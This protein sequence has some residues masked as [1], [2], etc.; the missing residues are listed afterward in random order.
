MTNMNTKFSGLTE[1]QVADQVQLHG[2]N[3]I[4]SQKRKSY[5]S[6]AFK[7]IQEPMILLLLACVAV[8]FFMGSLEDSILLLISVAL[9]ILI[10]LYQESKSSRALEALK[11]LSSPR[12]LVIRNSK[13]LRISAREVVPGDLLVLNE[14]D[15]IPADARVLEATNLQVNESLLTGESATIEK[16]IGDPVFSSTLVTSGFALAEV[17]QIGIATEVGKIGKSLFQVQ[18]TTTRLQNEIAKLIRTF[19]ILAVCFSLLIVLAYG[20]SRGNWPEGFLAGLSTALALLPEEFPVILTIFLALGAWRMS[21]INVLIRNSSATENLGSTTVLCVDKTGTLTLNKMTVQKLLSSVNS[22]DEE[23]LRFAELASRPNSIDPMEVA[24]RNRQTNR[25]EKFKI[26]KEFGL[27]PALPAMT[28]VILTSNNQRLAASKG[29]PEAI[30]R[31]CQAQD[32]LVIIE[33]ARLL[34]NEGYR[35]LAVAKSDFLATVPSEHS[36]LQMKYLG[37]IGFEDP[38]RPQAAQAVAE[39]KRAGIR[40]IMMTGDHPNTAAKVAAKIGIPTEHILTGQNLIEISDLE[41]IEKLKHANIFARMVPEQK[42][43][44]V[45]LLKENGE[46]VAMTGDGV[47]DGPSLRSADIGIAMGNKGT[48]VAREASDI[49]L[50]DDNFASIVAGIRQGRRIFHNIQKA[51]AYV[52]A[53]H[54]PIAGLAIFPV[55]FG[56]PVAFFP[57]HIVFIELIIDPS[58]TL[59]YES[60]PEEENEMN[61]PPRNLNIPLFGL[62]SIASSSAEGLLIFIAI[63]GLYFWSLQKWET[64]VARSMA[65]VGFVICNLGLILVHRGR[66]SQ[67]RENTAFRWVAALALGALS[68]SLTVPYLKRVFNFGSITAIQFFIVMMVALASILLTKLVKTLLRSSFASR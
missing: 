43:R 45:N 28:N 51:M 68:L 41:L 40:I 7:I 37:L 32:R 18:E 56:L 64:E 5:L 49:V 36:Q 14:G 65:F 24:I 33:Q 9:V 13:E 59:I 19:G 50:L 34:T 21:R 2:F 38:V 63:V 27:T 23:V 25:V 29:A 52:F 48:D 46:V 12:A 39:C 60:E 1:A 22:D 67:L 6:L 26:E 58:C 10:S 8:Y 53:I 57:A 31:L 4:P 20:F 30:A 42:L 47:N 3:E 55:L 35:V 11:D 16:K 61:R 15:R 54:V 66:L 17:T 44:V 62:R